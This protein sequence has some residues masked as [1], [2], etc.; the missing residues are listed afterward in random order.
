MQ[1]SIYNKRKDSTDSEVETF[2]AG[3]E[4]WAQYKLELLLLACKQ[5]LNE[6]HDKDSTRDVQEIVDEF[7]AISDA[8]DK[9]VHDHGSVVELIGTMEQVKNSD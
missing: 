8:T 2:V 6:L 7:R 9:D 3:N 1:K 4:I 5:F